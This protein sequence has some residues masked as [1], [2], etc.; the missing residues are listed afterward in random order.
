MILD[1]DVL[2]R[3]VS[4][5]FPNRLVKCLEQA[6]QPLCTTAINLAEIEYGI[7]KHSS[8][9]RLRRQYEERVW[10]WL[11][12]LPFDRESAECYGMLRAHLEQSG[13]PL[14]EADLMIASIALR[15]DMPLV[16]GNVRHFSRI[17]GLA[18]E[19]WLEP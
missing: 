7:A 18:L 17:P 2:S 10:P 5:A 14:A 15:N 9:E 6:P 12:V 19:N 3:L 13:M 4:P 11:E 8:P 1:T 16:S